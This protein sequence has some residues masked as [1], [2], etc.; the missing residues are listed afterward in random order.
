[1]S[2]LS[3][4]LGELRLALVEVSTFL[5]G[6]LRTVSMAEHVNYRSQFFA[7]CRIP[8]LTLGPYM[9]LF[10]H[11]SSEDNNFVQTISAAI[12]ENNLGVLVV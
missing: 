1:M 8:M 12:V 4:A 2:V 5:H 3:K 11:S 7:R 9:S 10:R 6:L